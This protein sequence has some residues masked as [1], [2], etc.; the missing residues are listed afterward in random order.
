MIWGCLLLGLVGVGWL[1]AR[2]RRAEKSVRRALEAVV[3]ADPLPPPRVIWA[4]PDG[5]EVIRHWWRKRA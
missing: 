1:H 2:S 4:Q 5:R 3:Q